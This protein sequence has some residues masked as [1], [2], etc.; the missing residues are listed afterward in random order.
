MAI[1]RSSLPDQVNFTARLSRHPF[2][3]HVLGYHDYM[4]QIYTNEFSGGAMV[5]GVNDL[6][7]VLF[8][9]DDFPSQLKPARLRKACIA[10]G[11]YDDARKCWP[12]APAFSIPS[13]EPA[14]AKFFEEILDLCRSLL[15]PSLEKELD[16]RYWTAAFRND[17]LPG[18]VIDRRPDVVELALN[19]DQIWENSYSD[20]QIKSSSRDTEAAAK[21]L[22][23]GAL[24]C[25]S[26]QDDRL[27]HIGLGVIE[28][29]LFLSCYDRCGCVRSKPIDIHANPEVFLWA[30]VGVS[31]LPKVHLGFDMSITRNDLGHR[32]VT[33]ED[34]EYLIVKQLNQNISIHGRGTVVWHGKK[35]KGGQDVA[36]KSA[37]RDISRAHNEIDVLK[38]ANSKKVPNVP[39]LAGHE[40]V[41]RRGVNASTATFR[42]QVCTPEVLEKLEVREYVRFVM[43]QYG[44]PLGAFASIAELLSVV[45]DGVEGH[46]GLY[47]E[48]DFIHGDIHEKNIL[49]NDR[50]RNQF[51]LRR[52][53]LVD[54]ESA[55]KV[56][57]ARDKAAKGLRSCPASHMSC[58]FL[59]RHE[60]R[61]PTVAD[62]LES[63]FY[64]LLWPCV[65]QEGPD[66]KLRTDNF[67]LMSKEMGKWLST[68]LRVVGC[69]KK[70]IMQIQAGEPNIFR[71]FLD[72]HVHPNFAGMKECLCEIR[73]VV[74]RRDP[75]PNH[76][77]VID[78]LRRHLHAHLPQ[79]TSDLPLHPI[80]SS[81]DEDTLDLTVDSVKP[82]GS[83]VAQP[84]RA[85]QQVTVNL[86]G[87]QGP[88]TDTRE[89]PW[90]P[91]AA[92]I[93]SSTSASSNRSNR[94]GT[95]TTVNRSQARMGTRQSNKKRTAREATDSETGFLYQ[96]GCTGCFKKVREGEPGSIKCQVSNCDVKIFHREC[97]KNQITGPDKDW[98]CDECSLTHASKKSKTQSA[99]DG[100]EHAAAKSASKVSKSASKVS[101][102]ASRASKSASTSADAAGSSDKPDTASE[103]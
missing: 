70:D 7:A 16:K 23:D 72:D 60:Y 34:V 86:P 100:E 61:D 80:S 54:F 58:G 57:E 98:I 33:V 6:H 51:G 41:K 1:K 75:P 45:L 20:A 14:M 40:N 62:D 95:K 50:E 30:L 46:F 92:A 79:G 82:L 52:G 69:L 101:K 43:E 9:K 76:Q 93:K 13:Q 36:I 66:G 77:D 2:N 12:H 83:D 4:E 99:V 22:H 26:T 35:V 96:G 68:D 18:G 48:C 103:D 89:G 55:W 5:K 71:N 85:E 15:P 42:A 64:V 19:L 38:L 21:Q 97:V 24:N 31:L 27:H 81:N 67:D 44:S 37:W 49:I 53:L 102:S 59:T 65:L 73:S 25:L 47:K 84:E 87:D 91:Q 28:R 90:Q 63:F 17:T 74:M 11:L 94:T 10:R 56:G 8:Q 78:V 88:E 3:T 32:L 29:M 39:T